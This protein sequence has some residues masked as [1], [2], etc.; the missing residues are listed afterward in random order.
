MT[1]T[2]ISE[3]GVLAALRLQSGSFDSRMLKL[4]AISLLW[5]AAVASHPFFR[6]V[7]V[8]A[9]QEARLRE[10]ILNQDPGEISE[11]GCLL[12]W[13]LDTTRNGQPMMMPIVFTE[14]GLDFCRLMLPQATLMIKISEGQL[15]E[16]LLSAAIGATDHLTIIVEDPFSTSAAYREIRH[17][18][19]Q[20]RL[21]NS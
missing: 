12:F 20:R 10:M 7:T 8:E 18:A 14:E 9:R 15:P 6:N 3:N 11:F 17:A 16:A 5:R 1:V 13:H 21:R 4:F 19:L 2:E